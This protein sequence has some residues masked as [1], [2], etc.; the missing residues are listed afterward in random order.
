MNSNRVVLAILLVS[1]LCLTG[2]V[3]QPATIIECVDYPRVPSG[4]FS[5]IWHGIIS[6]I[7]LIAQALGANWSVYDIVNTGG[8]YD[9]GFLLGVASSLGSSTTVKTS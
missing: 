3:A 8:W 2:C 6:P 4:F 7:S 1:L 9:F 5:G